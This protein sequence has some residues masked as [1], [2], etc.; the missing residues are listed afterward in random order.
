MQRDARTDLAAYGITKDDNGALWIDGRELKRGPN[1]VQIHG[2]RCC[3][4]HGVWVE[5][6]DDGNM[7]NIQD[8]DKNLRILDAYTHGKT[9][10]WLW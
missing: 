1:K 6:D 2:C 9:G 10:L 3:V 7:T 5:W 4:T 8:E